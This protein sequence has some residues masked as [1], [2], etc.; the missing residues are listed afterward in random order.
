[1]KQEQREIIEKFYAGKTSLDDELNLLSRVKT[2]N[3]FKLALNEFD[4]HYWPTHDDN[5][6]MDSSWQ[7]LK[8]RCFKSK[9][10]TFRLG[11]ISKYAAVFLFAILSYHLA[12]NYIFTPAK[13]VQYFETYVPK[14][15][16]TH[17]T[18]PDGSTVIINSESTLRYNSNYNIS[19]REIELVGEAY[20]KVNRNDGLPLDVVTNDYTTRVHGTA[21]NVMAYQD[22]SRTETTLVNGKV[23]ILTADK[24]PLTMLEPGEKIIYFQ[25]GGR[26]LRR[27]ADIDLDIS[28]KDNHFVFEDIAFSEL[29]KRL[30]RWYNVTIVFA[31]RELQNVLYSGKFKNEE[32][33]W[34]VL[35]IIKTNTPIEYE[36]EERRLTIKYRKKRL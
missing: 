15:E 34:Q 27:K 20:F 23:E 18:L 19:N 11:N 4:N 32:T 33:I 14:G 28:W 25:E 10:K 1:M 17:I 26:F 30:E 3:E 35:D 2:D 29:A 13:Q 36:L 9:P 12:L 21:F 6:R 8:T 24:Q 22:F 7:K 16:K 31:D 5:L